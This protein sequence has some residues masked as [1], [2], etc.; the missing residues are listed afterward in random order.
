MHEIQL[1]P[2]IRWSPRCLDE[3]PEVSP[4][5]LNGQVSLEG[6]HGSERQISVI[7]VV[8]VVVV[9]SALHKLVFE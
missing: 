6:R 8:V 3:P 9:V 7:V 1:H 4:A 2:E 5:P